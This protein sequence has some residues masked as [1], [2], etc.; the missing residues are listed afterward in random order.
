MVEKLSDGFYLITQSAILKKAINFLQINFLWSNKKSI[1][2]YERLISQNKNQPY[3]AVYVEKFRIVS[4]VLLF[5]QGR[6][7]IEKRGYNLSLGM[8]YKVIEAFMQ[9]YCERTN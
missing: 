8:L 4:A 7:E 5:H 1:K 2:I 6:S 9:L 3:G